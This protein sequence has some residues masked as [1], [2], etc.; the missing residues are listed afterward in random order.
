MSFGLNWYLNHY[1]CFNSW[2]LFYFNFLKA[3]RYLKKSKQNK[4]AVIFRTISQIKYTYMHI[5]KTHSFSYIFK[6]FALWL[7]Y[8]YLSNSISLCKL[9]KF[10]ELT[11]K[12]AF[13]IFSTSR[14]GFKPSTSKFKNKMDTN[15][16]LLLETQ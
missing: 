3:Q 13:F 2:F 6:F 7:T 4:N 11:K 1:N 14:L 9:C 10:L 15:Y 16:K 5:L 12:S 8:S